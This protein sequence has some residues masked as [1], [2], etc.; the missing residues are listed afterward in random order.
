MFTLNVGRAEG[1]NTAVCAVS[2]RLEIPCVPSCHFWFWRLAWMVDGPLN[3]DFG[4][5]GHKSQIINLQ[6]WTLVLPGGF[7]IHSGWLMWLVPSS[8]WRSRKTTGGCCR[9]HLT[10]VSLIWKTSLRKFSPGMRTRQVSPCTMDTFY[11]LT[12]LLGIP[13]ASLRQKQAGAIISWWPGSFQVLLGTLWSPL[14]KHP[15]HFCIFVAFLAFLF[16]F[17]SLLFVF[18]IRQ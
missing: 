5:S 11:Q 13:Q 7:S 8:V 9:A 16:L 12:W 15:F 10:A 17:V 14:L 18:P 6:G 3:M 4:I 2:L 1:G